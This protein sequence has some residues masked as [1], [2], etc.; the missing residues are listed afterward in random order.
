M[1][2][3]SRSS[4]QR[5]SSRITRCIQSKPTT[6]YTRAFSSLVNDTTTEQFQYPPIGGGSA[7]AL[8]SKP[9]QFDSTSNV[10]FQKTR[11]GSN[12]ARANAQLAS[13]ATRG[14]SQRALEVVADMK[15]RG[16]K[17]DLDTYNLLLRSISGNVRSADAWAIFEDM[18]SYGIKPDVKT[19]NALIVAHQH[20]NSSYLW[21][22]I[23]A[24]EE[25]GVEPNAATYSLI[26]TYFA[27]AKNI[28]AALRYFHAMKRKGIEP[29]LRTLQLIVQ[30]AADSGHARL[31]LD[32][33]N[34]FESDSVR[35]LESDVWI[36]CLTAS[37]SCL[38]KDG[39]IECWKY[40]VQELN[41]SPGEGLCMAVLHTA[42]RH[43][44]PDLATDVFRVLRLTG[45]PLQE[46]HV[47]PLIEAFCRAG[48]VK[49]AF[50]T[51][52]I[53]Q[54]T[55][56]ILPSTL[57]PILDHV[58]KNIDT[59]DS[60]W[61]L[62]DEIH[63][64][65]PLQLSSLNI[66]VRAAIALGDLQRAV[67]AYKSFPDYNI[68]A[69]RDTFHL[70]LEGTVAARHQALG[71][72]ILQDMKEA[73]IIFDSRT[74]ELMIDLAITQET[75]EE[76][77]QYLEEMKAAGFKPVA[78]TYKALVNRCALE[79][80]PRYTIALEEMEEMGYEVDSEFLGKA[81]DAFSLKSDEFT[82][83]LEELENS[84]EAR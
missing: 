73:Q 13:A 38:W 9:F 26:I 22:I 67:G 62:M 47:A 77:F 12:L 36:N 32:V 53:M 55:I 16:T 45:V 60:T 6:S 5:V 57:L 46:R 79:G 59:F 48:Q 42:A 51:V 21:P 58:K 10:E 56:P 23:R 31:A 25:M 14:D 11:D 65:R 20:R 81:K 7:D 41:L 19:F 83:Q 30:A 8:R 28:E 34:A 29:E 44:L 71:D 54:E 74:Y 63:K 39:V 37:A 15:L 80:D 2:R 4:V 40:V 52:D 50:M 84:G 72:R 70:L 75:Y 69:D 61:A 27:S 78:S 1:L 18:K 17:P 24:M 33:L 82:A 66:I 43:G 76:A 35:R 49:E 68:K 64:E 3:S